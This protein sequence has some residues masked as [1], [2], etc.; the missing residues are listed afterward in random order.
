MSQWGS[1]TWGI[2]S[3]L[4]EVLYKHD[5]LLAHPAV[6]KDRSVG[7]GEPSSH[8]SAGTGRLL[9]QRDDPLHTAGCAK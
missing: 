7:R 2:H 6:C 3:R 5:A 4:S 1:M 8:A 9:D